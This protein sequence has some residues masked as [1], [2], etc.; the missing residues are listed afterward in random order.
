MFEAEGVIA[1]RELEKGPK[2]IPGSSNQGMGHAAL[3]NK[4]M[5]NL[6]SPIVKH[7]WNVAMHMPHQ[8][9]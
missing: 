4:E 8:N 3:K 9:N 5:S 7:K 2:S 6:I 1:N